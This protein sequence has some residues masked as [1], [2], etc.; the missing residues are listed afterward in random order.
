FFGHILG[1]EICSWRLPFGDAGKKGSVFV[2]LRP[3]ALV[4]PEVMQASLAQRRFVLLKL[5]VKFQISR[6]QLLEEN[7]VDY[8]SGFNQL[9]QC[10]LI[11][12]GELA[13]VNFQARGRKSSS[14]LLEFFEARR[15][16]AFRSQ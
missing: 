13:G 12:G 1:I 11:S 15:G 6:P 8:A 14:H 10:F 4:D 7:V 16:S 9:D 3:R 5:P 2:D